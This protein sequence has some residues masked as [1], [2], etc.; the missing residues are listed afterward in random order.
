MENDSQDQLTG[1]QLARLIA[2]GASEG[3]DQ[4][5]LPV[6]DVSGGAQQHGRRIGDGPCG[7]KRRPGGAGG[8]PD[9]RIQIPKSRSRNVTF[10]LAGL[11]RVRHG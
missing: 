6:V 9:W 1:D 2:L 4:G 7:G 10:D 8:F 3:S 5:G 11:L